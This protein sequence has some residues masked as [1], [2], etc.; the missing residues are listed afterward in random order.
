VQAGATSMH[1]HVLAWIDSSTDP[2]T[3]T[4]HTQLPMLQGQQGQWANT[5]QLHAVAPSCN[6]SVQLRG[7][8]SSTVT[9]S[10]PFRK[11]LQQEVASLLTHTHTHK[12][13]VS[14]Q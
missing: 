9:Q 5:Q 4:N 2:H 13:Q 12:K 14:Q 10:K 7:R 3:S 11:A 8:G 1:T 6:G